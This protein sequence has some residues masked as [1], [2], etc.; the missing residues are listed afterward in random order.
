MVDGPV[1]GVAPAPC[2]FALQTR[3]V[4]RNGETGDVTLRM[5]APVEWTNPHGTIQGGF[6]AA[7]LDEVIGT[8]VFVKSGGAIAPLTLDL[9]SNF[10]RGL[11]PGEVIAKG[12][13]VSMG[14]AIAF[15][16]AELYDS[17]GQL[18]ATANAKARLIP[19]AAD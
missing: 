9:N 4:E 17:D 11:K 19:F 13:L 1:E 2:S 5:W 7:M 3:A 8:P 16:E 14:R 15:M 18:V 12:R 10:L 6:V